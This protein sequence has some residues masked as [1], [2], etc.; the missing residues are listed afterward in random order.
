MPH[1]RVPPAAARSRIA[2]TRVELI[3][4]GEA[5]GRAARAPLVV[6]LG[7]EL[8]AGKTTLVQAICRGYGVT[9]PVTSPTFALV[10]EYASSRGGVWHADLYRLRGPGELDALGWDELITSDRLG[11]IEWPARACDRLPSGTVPLDLDHV[12]DDPD[13]RILLA[14]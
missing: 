7:G 13:R 4:W 14:G 3:A 6:A 11:L 9:E 10:H 1:V 8:G 2:L 5:F 12:P